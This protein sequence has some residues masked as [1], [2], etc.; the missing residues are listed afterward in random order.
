MNLMP[1]LLPKAATVSIALAMLL[2]LACGSDPTPTPEP[3]ATPVPT[4][5][6]APTATPEP[7]ATP[8]P[9]PTAT[10]TP[11]PTATPT[12]EP[13]MT[14]T[15]TG[16][17]LLPQ[18]A[19]FIIDASPAALLSSS[20]TL[21]E[22]MLESAGEDGKSFAEGF[23]EETGID[24]HSVT[25]AE[26][27]MDA[28][29]LLDT[30][31]EGMGMEDSLPNFGAALY[32]QFDEDEIMLHIQAAQGVEYEPSTY[33]GYSV[34]TVYDEFGDPMTIGFVGSDAVVFGTE[35][36]VEEMLDVAA[37][38]VPGLSSKVKESLDSLG[39]RHLG[40]AMSLPPEF[41]DTL[42][43][44]PEGEDVM[45]EMGL[46]GALDM[47]A[48]VAPVSAMKLLLHDD[49]MEIKAVSFF[50]DNEAATASKEYSEGIVA[51]FG[52]MSDSPELQEFASGME[53]S[54]SGN[55]VTFGMTISSAVMEQL[56]AGM[57]MDMMP[58]PQ[59]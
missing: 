58:L 29:E 1:S 30:G 21:I 25:Y 15:F 10:P 56:F 14:G 50:D 39:E 16:G 9:A 12:P 47:S 57:G 43:M 28:S 53:V 46:M 52:V 4:A 40:I 23:W 54:Q 48:L 19:S 49:A 42:S 17:S 22:M 18:E 7:T 51:M 37:G 8:T 41:F 20:S 31:V 27:F 44:A 11:A 59:N 36:S 34:Y 33:R 45:P 38:G 32:G 24:L 13:K 26:I 2:V 35:Y 3:T 6:P 5:T 55:A